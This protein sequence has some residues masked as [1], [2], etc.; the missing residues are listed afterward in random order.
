MKPLG[1]A[2]VS[3]APFWPLNNQP[4]FGYHQAMYRAVFTLLVGLTL[5]LGDG[6]SA[7]TF[8][9]DG[10]QLSDAIPDQETPAEL[11]DYVDKENHLIK[12]ETYGTGAGGRKPV[13][14]GDWTLCKLVAHNIEIISEKCPLGANDRKS[15]NRAKRLNVLR[16]FQCGAGVFLGEHSDRKVCGKCGYTI[17]S[18]E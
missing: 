9:K 18:D 6:A 13:Y 11:L 12:I 5:S 16:D 3:V 10:K 4:A 1:A 15:I 2:E 17:K 14:R 7:L 8:G